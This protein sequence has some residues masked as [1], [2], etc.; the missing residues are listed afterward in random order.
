MRAI[1][2]RTIAVGI[3]LALS[4]SASATADVVAVVSAKSPIQSLS[5]NDLSDIFLG[6]KIRFP[7]GQQAI[8]LDLQVGSASR[9]EFYSSVVGVSAVQL[10]AHWSKVIFT[11]RGKPP[12][13]VADGVELRKLIASEVQS[14]GYIDRK[15]VDDSVRVVKVQD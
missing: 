8:P 5:K 6:R 15:L 2:S 1:R 9:D 13:V 12:K 3:A 4:A 10:K 14:I 11:G 7:N